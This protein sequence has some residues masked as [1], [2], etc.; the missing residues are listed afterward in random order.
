MQ[1]LL[2]P[3]LSLSLL[4]GCAH[5]AAPQPSTPGVSAPKPT[6]EARKLANEADALAM[7]GKSA[8]ALPLY[9][10]AWEQG[11]RKEVTLYN[12]ACTAALA[13]ERAEALTW[14]ERAVEAGFYVTQQL[15]T[16]ED[17]ASLREDPA[18]TRLV[19]R[20]AAN[21]A[22][23]N[24]AQNPEL[25]DELLRMMEE[26]QAARREAIRTNFKDP[27]VQERMR[28]IDQRNTARLKEIIAQVGW[29]TRTLVGHRG[30]KSAWLLVQHADL[31]PAFQKECLALLEKAVVAGEAAGEDLAYLTDRVLV[32]E[33]KPQRYGTQFH[34]VD[35]QLVPRPLEDEAQVDARREAVGLEPMEEYAAQMRQMPAPS[36]K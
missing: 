14:L 20:T 29:P 33:G 22:K 5:T 36:G 6:A 19:E 3:L 2:V 13:G 26:D 35:G 4:A 12:A 31:D 28:T 27:A 15:K 8:E 23:R 7:Q 18:F 16:D 34:M 10:R 21:E 32:A 30:A 1:R 17:L 25:R 9:R 11:V 24:A